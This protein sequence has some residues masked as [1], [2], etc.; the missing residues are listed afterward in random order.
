VNDD[1]LARFRA[2]II[3]RDGRSQRTNNIG[4]ALVLS[5]LAFMYIISDDVFVHLVA[6]MVAV[7]TIREWWKKR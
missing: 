1:Q 2:R 6:I 5:A 3:L 4:A 7:D